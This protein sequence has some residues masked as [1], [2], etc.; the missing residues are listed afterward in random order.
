MLLE[1]G[2]VGEIAPKILTNKRYKMKDF[3]IVGS[4][5]SRIVM[6]YISRYES[7]A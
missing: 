6:N 3:H 2:A 1:S 5:R 4:C 7:E